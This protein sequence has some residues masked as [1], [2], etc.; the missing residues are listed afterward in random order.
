MDEATFEREKDSRV[1][2]SRTMP[3]ITSGNRKHC[4]RPKIHD[5]SPYTRKGKVVFIERTSKL[6]NLSKYVVITR[7]NGSRGKCGICKVEP[8]IIKKKDL[9][10]TCLHLRNQNP[11]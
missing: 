1:N 11:Y 10:K 5:F 4:I 6:I 7:L 2:R 3:K 8:K 9:S